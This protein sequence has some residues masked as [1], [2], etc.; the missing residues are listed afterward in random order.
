MAML[1]AT[2]NCA[3]SPCP[4]IQ[5]E[6]PDTVTVKFSGPQGTKEQGPNL[7]D[8]KFTACYGS[9]AAGYATA[10]GGK[11]DV[12]TGPISGVTLT[13]GGSG[14]AVLGRVAPT[15]TLANKATTLGNATVTLQ[16]KA[17]SCNRPYWSVVSLS[18]ANG[19]CGYAEGDPVSLNTGSAVVQ[20]AASGVLTT[21]RVEPTLT[22]TAPHG[23]GATFG[24][25]LASNGNTP[26]TWSVSSVGVSGTTSG[27][28]DGETLTITGKCVTIESNA[29][30][31]VRT[32]RLE[33]T[34]T[35]SV[36][37]GSGAVLEVSL[38]ATTDYSTGLNVWTVESVS[39]TDGGSGYS[40]GASVSFNPGA[41]GVT[42]YG[43]YADIRVARTEPTVTASIDDSGGGS[44]ASVSVALS[45]VT[46][47]SGESYWTISDISVL[48][49]GSGYP[50]G[51]AVLI[52]V[53]DG[54]VSD[55]WSGASAVASVDAYGAVT[56][57]VIY[58]GGAYYKTNGE[59]DSVRV[60]S[61]GYF[62]KSDGV[63]QSISV[64][65]AGEYYATKLTGATFSNGGKYYVE[66]ASVPALVSDVTVKVAQGWSS[67]GSGAQLSATVD[68][69]TSS[70][71]FGQIA[72]VNVVSGGSGYLGWRWIYSCDCEWV[73]GEDAG[74]SHS[75]TGYRLGWPIA[76]N[77]G[78]ECDYV[79]FRCWAKVSAGNSAAG[80][81]GNV[82]LASFGPLVGVRLSSPIKSVELPLV[83]GGP[84]GV[85][86]VNNGPIS[87][88][89]WG[90]GIDD[91]FSG[92]AYPGR[93][94][95]KPDRIDGTDTA[96]NCTME[97]QFDGG[98]LPYWS[99]SSVTV[100]PGVDGF[101]ENQPILLT[102]DGGYGDELWGDGNPPPF[103]R[104]ASGICRVDPESGELSGITITDGGVF[105][106]QV[107]DDKATPI[108]PAIAAEI[109]QKL[110]S[111]G[112]GAAVVATINTDTRDDAFGDIA[113]SISGGNGYLLYATGY[114]PV[115]VH[116]R[117]AYTPPTVEVFCAVP[118]TS[119]DDFIGNRI[120][121]TAESTVNDCSSFAFDATFVDA[122]VSVEDGGD[123][124]P[125]FNG[126][127]KCCG[128]CDNA[129][130]DV[131][132]SQVS[133]YMNRPSGSGNALRTADNI[134][135]EPPYGA[136]FTSEGPAPTWLSAFPFPEDS[137]NMSCEADE[138]E[139]V[140]D[141]KDLHDQEKCDPLTAGRSK[142]TTSDS[143]L[144]SQVDFNWS[145]G[146]ATYSWDQAD[147]G[148]SETSI[149]SFSAD[150]FSKQ[151]SWNQSY[152]FNPEY[153]VIT[154]TSMWYGLASV[155]I[156]KTYT[157]KHLGNGV[158]SK[159]K[160]FP[161]SWD[162]TT[163]ENDP[164][165]ENKNW[166]RNEQ[167]PRVLW[168]TDG[169]VAY[170]DPR[171]GEPYRCRVLPGGFRPL[172]TVRR[173][174]DSYEIEVEIQ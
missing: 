65:S 171:P 6:L 83:I 141:L 148:V 89:E 56:G 1:G 18:V 69:N 32:G 99:V 46:G 66:D 108:A 44:G 12:D 158:Y 28:V 100:P 23:S 144:P 111:Q 29:V 78:G 122:T 127:N 125:A 10:P 133:V 13:K 86:G 115:W 90:D 26:E 92:W 146:S 43:A 159:C 155:N 51:A 59:I 106:Q 58:D 174:C 135:G 24:I 37:G 134:G 62:F 120:T 71:T 173:I 40:D 153:L 25:T 169:L 113:V 118:I 67:T 80:L 154:T 82:H 151:N 109:V 33:P 163:N 88:H 143:Q 64:D 57:V 47:W 49:G 112:S 20:Q 104:A 4:C 130:P 117:G 129:C 35:A 119:V 2:C 68:S 75:I 161:D 160:G 84:C 170:D 132:L 39:V 77:W 14:Y 81:C 87:S 70:A 101:S 97:E 76:D 149:A 93:I 55:Q 38:T 121:Y 164:R 21:Q 126:R 156:V 102:R 137:W 168:W 30:C 103:R 94:Q 27:Y 79:G 172:A 139:V 116:Y 110:P 73:Y 5:G 54:Q 123:V 45:E 167:D 7:L 3:C 53:A 11:P 52:S 140:F 63:I 91:E 36:S 114:R 15:I 85:P 147:L 16:Q 136:C 42:V 72:S 131:N 105:Y 60:W 145:G 61:G 48:G 128:K 50:D 17:D 74:A 19:G 162:L 150:I 8:L 31:V 107:H 34:V 95:V 41:G 142:T 98:Y 96:V 9:G 22:A 152:D 165:K 138:H 166:V 124:T 157:L